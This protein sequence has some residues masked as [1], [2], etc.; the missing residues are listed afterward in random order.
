MTLGASMI[1]AVA[2]AATVPLALARNLRRLLMSRAH[3][4]MVGAFGDM[5][6]GTHQRLELREGRVHL[7]GHRRLLRLFPDD[8][9]GQLLQ[10]TQ[11][12]NRELQQLDLSLELG[13]EL[14]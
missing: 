14:L 5:I 12:R 3:E 7:P 10:I 9:D 1:A 2:A 6:P 4:L 13:L 8:V 11:H